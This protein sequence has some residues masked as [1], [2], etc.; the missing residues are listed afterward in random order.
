MEDLFCEEELEPVLKR[1]R[2]EKTSGADSLANEILKYDG[3]EVS[4][5]L[6]EDY[7][8]DFRKREST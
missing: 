8:Y 3:C 4:D 6:L 2:N 1:L 5:K 7:E